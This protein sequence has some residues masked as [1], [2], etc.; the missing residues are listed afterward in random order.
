MFSLKPNNAHCTAL[1][2]IT[3]I[4]CCCDFATSTKILRKQYIV[5]SLNAITFFLHKCVTFATRVYA[6]QKAVSLQLM[7]ISA[8]QG[9]SEKIQL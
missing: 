5:S 4:I 2:I 9:Y 7:T 6:I 3:I 1:V 8:A